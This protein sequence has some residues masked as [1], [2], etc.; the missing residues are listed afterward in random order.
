MDRRIDIKTHRKI[1]RL[2]NYTDQQQAYVQTNIF[3]NK[4]T[5]RQT[6]GQL[7]RYNYNC[8]SYRQVDEVIDRRKVLGVSTE[9]TQ[10]LQ[11]LKCY[12]ALGFQVDQIWLNWA[13][14][15]FSQKFKDQIRL[16]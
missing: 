7:N 10:Y 11:D 2:T 5:K 12:L 3:N 13:K 8:I 1:N 4:Q 15:C 14:H 9:L 6:D 16:F